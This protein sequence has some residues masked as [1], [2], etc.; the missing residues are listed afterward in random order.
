MSTGRKKVPTV[1]VKQWNKSSTKHTAC[2][3]RHSNP[4]CHT[5]ES[6]PTQRIMSACLHQIKELSNKICDLHQTLN[7]A[8]SENNLLKRLHGRHTQALR[9]FEDSKSCLSQLILK[10]NSEV[11]NLKD[12]L[13]RSQAHNRVISQKLKATEAELM[14]I[15]DSLRGLQKLS[16]DRK[17]EGREQLLHKLAIITGKADMKEKKI[18]EMETNVEMCNSKFSHQLAAEKRKMAEAQELIACFQTEIDLVTQKIEEKERELEIQNIY[19]NRLIK[20]SPR[21]DSKPK[22]ACDSKSVQT[23]IFEYHLLL[24]SVP[25]L[26]E[27]EIIG[28]NENQQINKMA[29]TEY[30]VMKMKELEQLEAEEYLHEE[31][32]ESID[33]EKEILQEIEGSNLE[34][35][36][37]R[38]YTE[39]FPHNTLEEIYKE[40]EDEQEELDDFSLTKERQ[41]SDKESEV[42]ELLDPTIVN[43]NVHEKPRKHYTFKE[44]FENMH[45]GRPAYGTPTSYHSGNRKNSR[46]LRKLKLLNKEVSS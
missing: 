11:K 26:K 20:G 29:N 17:L 25:G 1:R 22:V 46:Q 8:S 9:K 14:G 41:D 35:E 23:D 36:E 15:R 3:F 43:D 31:V 12:L 4:L 44:T 16:D 10:H 30:N 19:S 6:G 2:S 13:S 39:N 38:D 5:A 27:L 32:K 40:S 21:K 42:Q 33:E 18:K 24:T 45:Q 37:E 28:E 7:V 34:E